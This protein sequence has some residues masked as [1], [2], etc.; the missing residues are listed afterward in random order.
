MVFDFESEK[1]QQKH[2]DSI[3]LDYLCQMMPP[4]WQMIDCYRDLKAQG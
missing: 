3:L 1:E 4:A 2:C